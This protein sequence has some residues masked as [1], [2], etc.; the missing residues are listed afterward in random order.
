MKNQLNTVIWL[1]TLV[2]ISSG[3]H[4]YAQGTEE[5]LTETQEVNLETYADLLRQDIKTQKVA[6]LSQLM[7]LSPEQA[8]A[9]WPIY[10]EYA[11]ELSVLGDE[12][13]AG[14]REYAENFSTMTDEEADRLA[15]LRL[16]HEA[17]LTALKKK[18]YE[19]FKKALSPVL[20]ARFLQI[21]NQLLAILDLQIASSLPI[22][23]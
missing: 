16:D 9:F 10:R 12:R 4:L 15:R 5:P 13:L 6:I 3:A 8:S 19:R 22:V 14:V 1:I 17:K 7:Q 20:A 21:E 11:K 23:Q 18:Y 2:I